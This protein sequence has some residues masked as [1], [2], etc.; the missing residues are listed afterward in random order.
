V[1]EGHNTVPSCVRLPKAF[2][3]PLR[4]ELMLCPAL[5]CNRHQF[6]GGGLV[7]PPALGVSHRGREEQR[8]DVRR[9][10]SPPLFPLVSSGLLLEE[11]Q[12]ESRVVPSSS[13][14]LVHPIVVYCTPKNGSVEQCRRARA[15]FRGRWDGNKVCKGRTLHIVSSGL[16]SGGAGAPGPSSTMPSKPLESHLL[17]R[18]TSLYGRIRVRSLGASCRLANRAAGGC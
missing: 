9:R 1:S 16:S 15:H 13:P 4:R 12:A 14:P 10:P 8:G 17:D 3:S 5:S 6:L 2:L 18:S 7:P 11:G